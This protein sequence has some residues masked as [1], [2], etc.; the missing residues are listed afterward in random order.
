MKG[1]TVGKWKHL[2]NYLCSHCKF[3][4]LNPKTMGEHLQ[5]DHGI[6]E[7]VEVVETRPV[8]VPLFDASGQLIKEASE[9]RTVLVPQR[10]EQ[11]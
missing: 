2:P 4:T 6:G 3:A 1:Y 7:V 10:L 9:K 11:S 8:S 5:E